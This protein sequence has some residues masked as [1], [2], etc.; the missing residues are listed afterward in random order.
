MHERINRVAYIASSFV[1]ENVGRCEQAAP[2]AAPSVF[3]A[4]RDGSRSG[5]GGEVSNGTCV[6]VSSRGE[7]DSKA[8]FWVEIEE[9]IHEAPF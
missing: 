8:G 2:S 7:Y 6:G 1:L 9:G 4:W 3:V 5:G